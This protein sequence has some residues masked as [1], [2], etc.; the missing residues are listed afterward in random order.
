MPETVFLVGVSDAQ[1]ESL[2]RQP[3]TIRRFLDQVMLR[4]DTSD[5]RTH[6][7]QAGWR[8]IDE[9]LAEIGG[10][11]D[12]PPAFLASGG[13]PVGREKVGRDGPAR[14][15]SSDEVARL[16]EALC[17]VDWRGRMIRTDDGT[18]TEDGYRRDDPYLERRFAVLRLFVCDLAESGL[19]MVLYVD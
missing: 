9:L 18:E 6:H 10:Y 7:L 3:A 2:Q 17:D 8:A 15:M 14:T 12:E 1:V 5:V 11:A 19:G 16:A 4:P 13:D